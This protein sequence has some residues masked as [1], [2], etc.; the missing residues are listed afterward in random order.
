MKKRS[1]KKVPQRTK[2]V[3]R[4]LKSKVVAMVLLAI[5]ITVSSLLVLVT[6]IVNRSLTHTLENYMEDVCNITGQNIDAALTRSGAV[7][8]N[9]SYLQ[10]LIGNVSINGVDSSY[11]YIVT[12]DG[13]MVYHPSEDKIGQPVENELIKGIISDM[14]AGNEIDKHAVISYNFDGTTKYA[15]YYITAGN[16]AVLVISA[17]KADMMS[18]LTYIL[19]AS[20]ICGVFIFIV[21]GIISYFAAAKMTKPLL[22]ITAVINRFST[23]NLAES[24]TTQRISKRKDE[25]GEIARAIAALRQ[26]LADIVSQIKEQSAKLYNASNELDLNASHTSETVGNVES[27]V[28]EI[29]TG[30]TSQASETQKATDNIVDMGTMIEHTN[31]KVENLNATAALMKQ[32]SDEASQTL[33][34]LDAINQKAIQ[35][36]DIIYEQTNTTNAS[37]LKI[38]EATSLISSIA[39]ETNLLSLNASIEAARA[40]DAGRGF[41]VV[42]SQIQKLAEQSDNSARQIDDIIHVLLE[43]SQKAVETMNEVKTI[44]QQ[45]SDNVT[46]TGTVFAQVRDGIGDSIQGMDEIAD[47]TTHL[48]EARSSVI[49]VVQSLTAIAQQNAASTQETSASVIEVGNTMQEI[50]TNAKELKEIATILEDNMNSFK[51]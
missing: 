39:E 11:A 2:G 29:A 8:L 5:A 15:A 21:C 16:E 38:K 9:A 17:D 44:M 35:S 45:Q 10:K 28:N 23:L 32:S 40:G 36:I 41:A 49:D 26:Q 18:S 31:A 27:A 37:A 24:P 6:S 33:T 12:N 46:K 3:L 47:R 51:L 48:D 20:V 42:A 7:I 13:T 30:A 4:S 1:Q 50:S 25:T 34:E 43:D 22:E 19:Q 14:K